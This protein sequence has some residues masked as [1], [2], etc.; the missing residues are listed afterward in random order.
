MKL[1]WALR[2]AVS[3]CCIL[4]LIGVDIDMGI[5]IRIPFPL[6][7]LKPEPSHKNPPYFD[8]PPRPSAILRIEA[9]PS[10]A[11]AQDRH[12]LLQDLLQPGSV[13]FLPRL[14][15]SDIPR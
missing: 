7:A 8:G 2:W 5:S 9:E 4:I 3:H 11:T 15:H 10:P 14:D 12:R 1:R 13:P 6:A